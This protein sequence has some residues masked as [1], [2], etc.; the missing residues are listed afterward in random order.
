M[1]FIFVVRIKDK[2]DEFIEYCSKKNIDT[3]IHWQPG[4]LFS[5]LRGCKFEDL[6]VTEKIGNQIVTIPMY[7]DL[8]EFE[9]GYIIDVINKFNT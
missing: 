2:R 7:P 1:P 8:T 6:S 3:G 5:Y 9:Q 4:H